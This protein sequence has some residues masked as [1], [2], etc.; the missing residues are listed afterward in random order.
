M[1]SFFESTPLPAECVVTESF[2]LQPQPERRMS[3][4]GSYADGYYAD[5][6]RK[7]G[8]A[9]A[10]IWGQQF[11]LLEIGAAGGNAISTTS[12]A[13]G[14]SLG[15]QL[16]A[17]HKLKSSPNRARALTFYSMKAL[18]NDQ[19]GSWKKIMAA[20]GYAE[21]SLGVI[22]GS[23]PFDD[24][25][26]I[27]EKADVA[28]MTPDVTHAW[29]MTNLD[30]A[31]VR[32]FIANRNFT[33][34]DELQQYDGGFGTNFYYLL[35]RL[36]F[37]QKHLNPNY[38]PHI[39]GQTFMASATLADPENFAKRLTGR[40]VE[41]VGDE[42]NTAPR[43]LRQFEVV[44]TRNT[45]EKRRHALIDSLVSL[46]RSKMIGA[47]LAFIDSRTGV[48]EV[49]DEVNS[50]LGYDAFAA[51]RAG[52]T[53]DDREAIEKL[54][55]R[56][57]TTDPEGLKG[58]VTTS[59][60]EVGIDIPGI[61]YCLLEGVPRNPGAFRQRGG[62]LRMGGHIVIFETERNLSALGKTVE[63]HYQSQPDQPVIYRTNSR[64]QAENALCLL[65]EARQLGVTE[66]IDGNWPKG[67]LE[68]VNAYQQEAPQLTQVQLDALPPKRIDPHRFHGMRTADGPARQLM[69]F[70]PSLQK[71][72]TVGEVS[73]GQAL[74]EALPGML[75][76]VTSRETS[77]T[78]AIRIKTRKYRVKSWGREL[79][80]PVMLSPLS[81]DEFKSH[82]R[83]RASVRKSTHVYLNE[84]GLVKG[85]ISKNGDA[86]FMAECYLAVSQT[87]RGFVET[88]DNPVT[89]THHARFVIYDERRDEEVEREVKKDFTIVHTPHYGPARHHRLNT[90]GVIIRIGENIIT[91]KELYKFGEL[92][93]RALCDVAKISSGE[94]GVLVKN[95]TSHI[96]ASNEL[97]ERA[98]VIYDRTPGSL[99]FSGRIFTHT[100]DV[101]NRMV[102]LIPL[103]DLDMGDLIERFREWH[104]KLKRVKPLSY[105]KWLKKGLNVNLAA[106]QITAYRPGSELILEKDGAKT[107]VTIAGAEITH[108]TLVYRVRKSQREFNPFKTKASVAVKKAA[109][110]T[111]DEL[112]VP[113]RQ[114]KEPDLPT[115][116]YSAFDVRANAYVK[117]PSSIK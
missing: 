45:N 19:R 81:D 40:A 52:L 74:R 29:F 35:K 28:L 78:G 44:S 26:G 13:S 72:V 2:A 107:W 64:L 42:L 17:L 75:V 15:F 101:L 113:A 87:A 11:R 93:S 41:V 36:E 89:G 86:N 73:Q 20:A 106:D 56:I 7:I 79:H 9:D 94:I 5:I 57:N 24:R 70:S 61:A 46:A 114:L 48:E 71:N 99:F 12:T 105:D 112:F 38:Q 66:P 98:I 33:I 34:I 110:S 96:S 50:I 51:Y 8:I 39:H 54:L 108:N 53:G 37:V 82:I 58:V 14:K 76:R 32:E 62:R 90:S 117:T 63:E 65:D 83:T 6:L 23:V 104:D 59:A 77:P 85:R 84:R 80:S 43:Y 60:L 22:D 95:V 31:P 67:F 21:E 16:P 88:I 55:G 68:N 103:G 97:T 30:K 49:V 116:W 10:Q 1:K 111:A 25:M 102:D 4:P 92:M 100:H 3:L 109:G 18:S 27:L 69:R 47:A 115:Y 91:D